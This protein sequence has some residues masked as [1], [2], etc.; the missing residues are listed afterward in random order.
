M[1]ILLINWQDPHNPQ[2]GGAEVHLHEIF[3]RLVAAGNRVTWVASGWEGAPSR[4]ELD[5]LE[6]HRTGRRYTFGLRAP[7]YVR[8]ELQDRPWDVTVEALNKVPV[9]SPLWAPAP[10]V[11]L[12]HHLFGSTAFAEAPPPIAA[13]TWLQE[14]PIGRL[15]RGLPAQA[16]SVSTADDLVERGLQREDIAVIHPG[17]DHDFFL[18]APSPVRASD[19]TFLYLGRLQRYKRVDLI[20]QAF[21]RVRHER[22]EAR[23]VIAGRGDQE[24]SLRA[25]ARQL[26]AADGVEFAGYVTEERKRDLLRSSWANVFVSP[27]E[28]W[29]I[30]NL[31]A[32]ACGTPTI[33]SNAPGLRE[34]VI[35]G[36]TGLLVPD[37]DVGALATAMLRLTRD[38]TFTETLG[39]QALDFAAGF[40]WD[41]AARATG[42]H[43]QNA[44]A[45]ATTNP[46]PT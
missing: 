45:T 27:K 31:E 13:L 22:P 32:A 25:I 7:L 24:G 6:I 35:D 40:T 46:T 26:G 15:Y 41:N 37:G 28:G 11:L 10:Q 43:L 30:T 8:R 36:R 34:S 9:Y 20:V 17:V 5:G 3:S 2:A 23:L 38:P 33:A 29:G 21:A 42:Q 12:V 39:R 19:P 1:R 16:I 14:R 18:P 4:A 44:A